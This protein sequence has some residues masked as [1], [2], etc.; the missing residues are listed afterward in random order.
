MLIRTQILFPKED[1]LEIKELAKTRK[2][3]MSELVRK[4]IKNKTLRKS[5]KMNGAEAM[6]KMAEWAKKHNTKAPRD[7]S[8]ND[9]Y[10]YGKYTEDYKRIFKR[11]KRNKK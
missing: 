3:S 4:E 10:L 2:I 1:L 5:G 7:L 6:L 11:K 9:D 8:S